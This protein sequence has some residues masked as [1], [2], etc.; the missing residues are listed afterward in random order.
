M[1]RRRAAWIGLAALV[2]VG[3]VVSRACVDGRAAL[4]AGDAAHAKAAA[5]RDAGKIDE[6]RAQEEEAV[7]R[8]RRAARWY[9]PG[10]PHV[11]KAYD[12]LEALAAAATQA[13]DAELALMAWRAVRSSCLATRSF[14][15]PQ[16]ARLGRA[17]Q[18]IATLMARTED[19]ATDPGKDEAARRAWH[20]ALLE[21]DEAPSV[22]WSLLA[23][24]GFATWV[25]GGFWFAFRGLDGE[26]RLVKREAGRAGVLV[27]IGMVVW[28]LALYLA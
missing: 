3:A 18:A 26:D 15:V 8:W 17:N 23:V 4:A 28:A 1:T 6:A 22:G 7:T 2:C 11:G 25:G 13:G 21:R 24:L 12:R 10:A 14:Y 9:L 5:L 19:P 20:L 27:A 16:R